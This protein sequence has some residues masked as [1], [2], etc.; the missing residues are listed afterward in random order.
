LDTIQLFQT[1]GVMQIDNNIRNKGK[2][3]T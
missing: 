3:G 2:I 1:V